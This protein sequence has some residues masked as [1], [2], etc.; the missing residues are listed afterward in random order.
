MVYSGGVVKCCLDNPRVEAVNCRLERATGISSLF[1][2]ESSA[3]DHAATAVGSSYSVTEWSKGSL[4]CQTGLSM[5]GRSGF[6]S[7]SPPNLKVRER[8]VPLRRTD[9]HYGSIWSRKEF[10]YE[11]TGRIFEVRQATDTDGRIDQY[12]PHS[13]NNR[14]KVNHF[15]TSF[16][17]PDLSS[18]LVL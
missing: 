2:H 5:T 8:A 18:G 14:S 9:S 10:P 4:S 3:L 16:P 13:H 1:Q 15:I 11:Y 17:T 6:E 12:H 7:R